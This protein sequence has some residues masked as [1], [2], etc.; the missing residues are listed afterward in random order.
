MA[1]ALGL[2]LG[3]YGAPETFL[4]D[5]GIIHIAMPVIQRPGVES[6]IKPLWDK[7]ARRLRN[8]I[9]LAC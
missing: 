1:T 8:E 6:E 9:L 5:E 4:I 3:V 7:L 2:D